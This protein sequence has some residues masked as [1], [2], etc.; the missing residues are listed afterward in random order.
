MKVKSILTAFAVIS[1]G[2]SSVALAEVA[3]A[4]ST[5][6]AAASAVETMKVFIVTAKGGG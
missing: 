2:G 1:M 5:E 4:A 6:K 3:P